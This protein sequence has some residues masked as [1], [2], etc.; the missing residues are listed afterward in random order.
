M[1]NFIKNYWS[2]KLKPM[3]VNGFLYT[4]PKVKHFIS[5]HPIW[6]IIIILIVI[7]LPFTC[8]DNYQNNKQLQIQKAER[9]LFVQDSL[10]KNAAYMKSDEYKQK[11]KTDSI[12]LIAEK[13]KQKQEALVLEKL[14][15]KEE[16]KFL[17][18]KAGKYYKFC[19]SKGINVSKEDCEYA[20]A[21]NVW[22]GMNIWLLVARRGNPNSVNTSNYGNGNRYQYCWHD[23][24]PGCFYD[25]DND[26]L[27]DSYN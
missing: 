25:D 2:G 24:N 3:I 15:K 18:S 26:N 16:Q 27:V 9:E 13:K 21:G 12:N 22:V 5:I 10:I 19:K 4:K 1:K 14:R 7:S 8:Y 11:L 6:S 23:Y 17:N 20:A